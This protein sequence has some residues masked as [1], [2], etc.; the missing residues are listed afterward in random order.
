MTV[1]YCC[2]NCKF[3]TNLASKIPCNTCKRKDILTNWE[4]DLT[5]EEIKN[6]N[7]EQG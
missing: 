7:L 1:H 5:V 6:L 4:K 2:N 3:S